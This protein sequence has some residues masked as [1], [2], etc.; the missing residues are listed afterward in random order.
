M[1]IS[2]GYSDQT[3]TPVVIAYADAMATNTQRANYLADTGLEILAAHG[4]RGLTHRA[5]DR[6]SQSPSGTTS[7]YFPSRAKLLAALADRI[8]VRLQ[9]EAEP[10]GEEPDPSGDLT[11]YV[12]HV[13]DI[14]TRITTEPSL[15]LAL[16]ELRLEA[17]RD[18]DLAERLQRTLTPGYSEDLAFHRAAELPGGDISVALLHFAIDGLLLDLLSPPSMPISTPTSQWRHWFGDWPRAPRTEIHSYGLA[19]GNGPIKRPH[20]V[21]FADAG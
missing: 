14:V 11:A 17:T 6:A 18:N 12:A 1:L 16:V 21:A 8:F 2:F 13:H 3:T 4:A 20:S 19:N 9:P 7:N 5:V 15:W 10:H